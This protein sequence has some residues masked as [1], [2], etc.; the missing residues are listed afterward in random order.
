LADES[1]QRVLAACRRLDQKVQLGR[2]VE[3]GSVRQ[4]LWRAGIS[5]GCM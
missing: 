2:K 3:A 5:S 1:I 4:A